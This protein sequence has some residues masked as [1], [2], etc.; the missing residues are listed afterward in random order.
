MDYLLAVRK[1]V[2]FGNVFLYAISP[3]TGEN[4]LLS[5]YG[6]NETAPAYRRIKLFRTANWIRIAYRKSAPKFYSLDDH[7]PLKSRLALLLAL[8]AVKAYSEQDVQVAHIYEAD[9]ARLELEAQQMAEPP[10]YSPPEVIQ[11]GRLF[12]EWEMDIR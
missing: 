3:D 5:I 2:T 1:D 12:P 10:V 6:P 8:R 9:A 7:I 11:E 4:L